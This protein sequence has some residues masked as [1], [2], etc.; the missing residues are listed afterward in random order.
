MAETTTK[1]KISFKDLAWA[2]QP[3]GMEVACFTGTVAGSQFQNYEGNTLQWSTLTHMNNLPI[4]FDIPFIYKEY[5]PKFSKLVRMPDFYYNSYSNISVAGPVDEFYFRIGINI[6]WT[7]LLCGDLS[8]CSISWGVSETVGIPRS[9][10]LILPYVS[11]RGKYL[12][13]II[14]KNI[15]IK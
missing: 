2:S 10:S 9:S 11:H 13:I 5:L 6:T 1:N 12:K 15:I 14:I 7:K 4:L 3:S 8:S